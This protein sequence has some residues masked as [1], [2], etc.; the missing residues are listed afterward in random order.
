MSERKLLA[1]LLGDIDS[2]VTSKTQYKEWTHWNQ[3]QPG[4]WKYQIPQ[5]KYHH[6]SEDIKPYEDDPDYLPSVN[7]APVK[8]W[9][10]S[11]VR[12]SF[13][14]APE[15]DTVIFRPTDW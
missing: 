6:I 2:R 4:F 12:L 15:I 1:I 7:H 5:K 10:V 11:G 13:A 9:A 8:H 3:Y 14:Y